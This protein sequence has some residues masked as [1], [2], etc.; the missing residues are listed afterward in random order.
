MNVYAYEKEREVFLGLVIEGKGEHQQEEENG[1][2]KDH[3]TSVVSD[4]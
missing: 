4:T 3:K 1:C 2:V